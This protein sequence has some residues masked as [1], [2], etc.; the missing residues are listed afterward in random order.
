[1]TNI[2]W[3]LVALRI[4]WSLVLLGVLALAINVLVWIATGVS[5]IDVYL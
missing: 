1:M 4:V 2:D 3:P 5:I